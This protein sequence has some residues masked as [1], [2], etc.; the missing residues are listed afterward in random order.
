MTK[1]EVEPSCEIFE[2]V[3]DAIDLIPKEQQ[4]ATIKAIFYKRCGHPMDDYNFEN[5]NKSFFYLASNYNGI[6]VKE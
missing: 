2:T 5:V 6:E 1:Y 3:I 4:Y